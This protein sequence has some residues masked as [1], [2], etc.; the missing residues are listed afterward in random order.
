MRPEG[1]YGDEWEEVST[2][3]D[4]STENEYDEDGKRIVPPSTRRY[5]YTVFDWEWIFL[6]YRFILINFIP[7]QHLQSV[8]VVFI[9][10]VS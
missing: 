8:S 2:A 7:P 6:C 5:I 1:D 4:E 10:R 9:M 3:S